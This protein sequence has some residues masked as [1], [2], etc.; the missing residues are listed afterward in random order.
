MVYKTTP[1]KNPI[2]AA[3]NAIPVQ[4]RRIENNTSSGL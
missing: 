3:E 2:I 4:S 1:K